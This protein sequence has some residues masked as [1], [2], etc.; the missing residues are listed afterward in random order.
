VSVRVVVL[1]LASDR[2]RR[3]T[4]A[5][6]AQD[7]DVEWSF[8]DAHTEPSSDLL[9]DEARAVLEKGRA[10]S[11]GELGCYSS[12]F[13]IWCQ[14]LDDECDAYVVLEDDVVADWRFLE[15]L[16]PTNA[17]L[18]DVDFVRLYVKNL[19]PHVVRRRPFIDRSRALIELLDLSFGAQAY[20]I[21]KP[22]AARFVGC[23]QAIDRPVDDQMSRFWVHGIPNFAV[24]PAPVFERSSD[25][26]IGSERFAAE[27]LPT[28]RSWARKGRRVEDALRKRVVRTARRMRGPR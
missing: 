1:S 26:R 8:F 2:D 9:Y 10:L 22:A 19:T 24:F 11:A 12:H 21:A 28:A 3:R 4:F 17:D 18:A 15:A 23:S 7:A 5:T 27:G 16:D 13:A 14:L 6:L 20:Y 25:S